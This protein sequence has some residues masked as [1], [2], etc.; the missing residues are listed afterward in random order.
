MG[1]RFIVRALVLM[2]AVLVAAESGAFNPVHD[3][4]VS[5]ADAVAAARTGDLEYEFLAGLADLSGLCGDPPVMISFERPDGFYWAHNP[6]MALWQN[7]DLDIQQQ[8]IDDP[9]FY[10]EWITANAMVSSLFLPFGGFEVIDFDKRFADKEEDH[11]LEPSAVSEAVYGDYYVVSGNATV[12]EDGTVWDNGIKIEPHLVVGVFQTVSY[13]TPTSSGYEARVATWFRVLAYCDG[14]CYDPVGIYNEDAL[15]DAI[16]LADWYSEAFTISSSG[17]GGSGKDTKYT[18]VWNDP[19]GDVYDADDVTYMS[20]GTGGISRDESFDYDVS[21]PDL[22]PFQPIG[23]IADDKTTEDCAKLLKDCK[24]NTRRPA[25]ICTVDCFLDS[26]TIMVA[27]LGC[28][29]TGPGAGFCML[30]CTYLAIV[31]VVVC[32]TVCVV[33]YIWAKDECADDY[34]ACCGRN[35]GTCPDPV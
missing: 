18:H 32:D 25:H 6:G 33:T 3:D 21:D 1:K 16:D 17:S 8:V 13:T 19:D 26:L 5:G 12:E 31:N 7:V 34:L 29:L 23:G 15:A 35:P 11:P 4:S 14:D 20:A 24:R 9:D 27:C 10:Q 2:M 22:G 28:S 30:G